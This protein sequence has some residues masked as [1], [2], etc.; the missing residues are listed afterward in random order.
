MLKSLL[1]SITFYTIIPLPNNW[2]KSFQSIAAWSPVVGLL[3]GTI[4]G[5]VDY[6][7]IFIGFP[8]LIR[9]TLIVFLGILITGG[10]HLDGVID[11]ADGITLSDPQKKLMAMQDSSCLLY[12][13]PSPRDS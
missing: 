6:L 12:T 9:S 2:E 1:G 13:S 10:L 3:I 5:L 4:L 8:I 7:L 11:S